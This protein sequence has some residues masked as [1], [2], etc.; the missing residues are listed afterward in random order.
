[1]GRGRS[2]RQVLSFGN[3][4]IPTEEETREGRTLYNGLVVRF[5]QGQIEPVESDEREIRVNEQFFG[6]DER[7]QRIVLNREIARNYAE[8][9][10]RAN[11]ERSSIFARAFVRTHRVPVGSADYLRGE[12][13]YVEGLYGDRGPNALNESARRALVEYLQNP[14]ALKL[15]SPAAYREVRRFLRNL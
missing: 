13:T 6:L 11:S 2:G 14:Q 12:R 10:V 7:Q 15:R 5:S 3:M 9:M 8:R 4:R 1:M